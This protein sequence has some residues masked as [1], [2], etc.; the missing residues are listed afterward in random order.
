MTNQ[1][2]TLP[3]GDSLTFTIT[4][5][6][7]ESAPDNIF[8]TIK[9]NSQDKTPVI[10]KYIGNGITPLEDSENIAYDVY[11]SSLETGELELLNYVYGIKLIYGSEEN[12]EV[13]GKFIITPERTST[14]EIN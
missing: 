13:E 12:T 4:L 2:F 6:D 10:Q 14:E 1:N 7:A 9:K 5:V 8:L 11:I 3:K